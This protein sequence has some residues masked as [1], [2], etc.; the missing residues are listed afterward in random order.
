MAPPHHFSA[1]LRGGADMEVIG[2][3]K[4]LFSVGS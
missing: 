1:A 4:K 2:M 3:L